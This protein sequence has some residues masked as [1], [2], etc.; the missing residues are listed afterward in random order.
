VSATA[1]LAAWGEEPATPAEEAL[2]DCLDGVLAKLAA[3]E[4]VQA[5]GLL[6]AAP[7]LAQRGASLVRDLEALC[8][9]AGSVWEH[10]G[11]GGPIAPPGAVPDPFPGEFRLVRVLGRG[12]FGT[13]WL[14]EDLHLGRP[15]ALKTL[16]PAGPPARVGQA[17]AALRNEARLLAAVRHPNVLPVYA[18]RQSGD[19][20]YLALQYVG[21][22]SLAD[23]VE[24]AGPLAWSLAA[25]YVADV[26]DGLGAVHAQGIVHRDIKPANILWDPE[27]DEALL[28]DFGISARLAEPA[29][30][31]GSPAFMAPEAFAGHVSP[32]L[33]VYGL[34]ATL[35]RLVTGASPFPA[36]NPA[37]LVR[38]AEQGLPDPEPRCAS[39]PAA[40][41]ALVRASLAAPPE[42]RPALAEFAGTLRGTLNHLLADT[43]TG[44]PAAAGGLRLVVSRQVGRDAF[45]PVRASQPPPERRL[46]DLKRVP[47]APDR[48]DVCTGDRVRLEVTADRP[49]F[50][51]VLNVGPGGNLNLLYPT[52]PDAA[53]VAA[54]EPLHVVDVELTPPTGR[55]RLFALWSRAPLSLGPEELLGLAEGGQVPGPYRAT[56]DMARVQ[57]SVQRLA[58]ADW[59]AVVLELNHGSPREAR[60]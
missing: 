60:R 19:E 36:A 22:G 50:V 15:V 53:P 11:L 55:E 27:T 42:R 38:L 14:A 30:V 33:D 17:L 13:V 45:V 46:R 24:R 57:E 32:A 26:A 31:A 52:G 18:W 28:T 3:G 23:R 6:P 1:E 21:G 54:G 43:L 2:A 51:T 40:L 20:H 4:P 5:E 56:R 59:H 7:A 29:A 25:R 49:G 58:P 12:T 41:E 35:F 39:L 44:L 10:A 9:A 37:E 8:R 34:A 48:V 16:R 47:P